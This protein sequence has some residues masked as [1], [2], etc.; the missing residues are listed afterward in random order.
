MTPK[1]SGPKMVS[2]TVACY[3]EQEVIK[4][5]E[6]LARVTAGLTIDNFE[7]ELGSYSS[8]FGISEEDEDEFLGDRDEEG[9]ES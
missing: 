9:E 3:S 8:S 1:W 6:V 4:A 7:T 2:L 5:F